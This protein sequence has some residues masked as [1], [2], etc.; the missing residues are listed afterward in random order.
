MLQHQQNNL[1]L[2]KETIPRL[3]KSE[4]TKVKLE[5]P[6]MK[7]YK[8][9]EKTAMQVKFALL[10]PPKPEFLRI[11]KQTVQRSQ[12]INFGFLKEIIT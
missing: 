3:K 10:A 8:R 5:E 2:N 7:F 1:E 9:E 11:Q 4:L 12:T 6:E